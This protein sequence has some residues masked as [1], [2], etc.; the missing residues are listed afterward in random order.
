MQLKS[1]TQTCTSLGMD[2]SEGTPPKAENQLLCSRAFKLMCFLRLK[3]LESSLE[4][5][6]EG[7]KGCSF[8]CLEK[9]RGSLPAP[10][11]EDAGTLPA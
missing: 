5:Q 4:R 3:L 11:G 1:L 10:D 2:K 9:S 7:K 8:C 6:K